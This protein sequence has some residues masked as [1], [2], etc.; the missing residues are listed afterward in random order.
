M[1]VL[2]TC[3]LV[4][5]IFFI[6]EPNIVEPNQ[7]VL[8]TKVLS[9]AQDGATNQPVSHAVLKTD[10]TE[11]FPEVFTI[12]Y[13]GRSRFGSRNR[14]EIPSNTGDIWLALEIVFYQYVLSVRLDPGVYFYYKLKEGA[15]DKTKVRST[16]RSWVHSCVALD[17]EKRKIAYYEGGILRAEEVEPI[18]WNILAERD[19][20]QRRPKSLKGLI[21]GTDLKKKKQFHSQYSN[22]NIFKRFLTNQE[23]EKI[24]SCK[25]NIEGDYFAWTKS[26]WEFSGDNYSEDIIPLSEVCQQEKKTSLLFPSVYFDQAVNMCS[27]L[28]GELWAPVDKISH[29]EFIEANI[30]HTKV[31]E[32]RCNMEEFIVF[33]WGHRVTRYRENNMVYHWYTKEKLY[34]GGWGDTQYPFS[35]VYAFDKDQSFLEYDFEQY[36]VVDMRYP[37]QAI[38]NPMDKAPFCGSCVFNSHPAALIIKGLCETTKF[39]DKF[40]NI[41]EDLL[42]NFT[43]YGDNSIIVYNEEASLWNWTIQGDLHTFATSNAPFNTF[44]IGKT[45]WTF[46]GDSCVATGDIRDIKFTTCGQGGDYSFFKEEF[47][48]NDGSCVDLEERCDGVPNCDDQ[49]D[50]ENCQ[51]VIISKKYPKNN[52]PYKI[53]QQKQVIKL[54]TNVSVK[55]NEILSISEVDSKFS[56]KFAL[57]MSWV[58]NRLAFQNLKS[59]ADQNTLDDDLQENLWKPVLTFTNTKKNIKTNTVKEND[60][61]PIFSIIKNSTRT[62]KNEASSLDLSYMFDGASNPVMMVRDYAIDFTCDFRLAW[63]PFDQQECHIVLELSEK[64]AKYIELVPQKV[65]YGGPFDLSQYHIQGLSIGQMKKTTGGIVVTVTLGRKLLNTIMTTYIPTI[66]LVIIS[67]GT[68]FYHRDLFETVIAVNL[69]CMLVLGKRK[70]KWGWVFAS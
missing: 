9:F 27:K 57:Y 10:S 44:L 47:T 63:Y 69:T 5:I 6:S 28:G 50:E 65:T 25:E 41:E 29:R 11:Q 67:Y 60:N 54:K 51:K 32:G 37:W 8:S 35:D 56:L 58:D 17:Y 3:A 66:L 18:A 45:S 40:F 24:T 55:I 61:E 68:S 26:D 14:L 53:S 16:S 33:Y 2:V 34:P 36:I 70:H 12:C 21:L 46:F 38:L 31:L 22:I 7:N 30:N 23:M 62:L 43:F 49:S 42:G 15:Y 4:S 20:L 13:S 39:S 19:L 64:D 48:C 52:I 1:R 59:D